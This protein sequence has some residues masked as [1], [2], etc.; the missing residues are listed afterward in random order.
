M[1]N[2]IKTA[3]HS[4][5]ALEIIFSSLR[6]LFLV[7]AIAVFLFQYSQDPNPTKGLFFI[8]LVLFGILYMGISEFYLRVSE[9]GSQLYTIMT[10]GGPFFDFIAFSALVPLTGGIDSPLIPVSYLIILHI[11]VYWKL[12]GG[13]LSAIS[14]AAVYTIMFFVEKGSALTSALFVEFACTVLFLL[15]IGSLGGLIVSR[16][17]KLYIDKNA[18]TEAANRDYLT[19]LLNYRAFQQTLIDQQSSCQ[20]FYLVLADIDHFKPVNDTYGHVIGDKVLRRIAALIASIVP[21]HRGKVFRYG[22]EEFAILLDGLSDEEVQALLMEV[23]ESIASQSFHYD[24]QTFSITLSFGVSKCSG[25]SC[26]EFVKK[27]DKLLYQAKAEG[28]NRIVFS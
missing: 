18:L 4:D 15:L 5:H 8:G 20:E 27:V 25:E 11:T 21:K 12:Y 1:K 6:W 19:D 16:E 9:E 24:E 10:K 3:H 14:F 22:G 13:L 2:F 17:R 23:K 28:R 7:I 26:E